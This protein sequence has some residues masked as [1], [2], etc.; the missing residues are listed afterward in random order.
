MVSSK[1]NKFAISLANC[2]SSLCTRR[3][4]AWHD[5]RPRETTPPCDGDSEEFRSLLTK[6]GRGRRA[7]SPAWRGGGA[8]RP[9]PDLAKREPAPAPLAHLPELM[10]AIDDTTINTSLLVGDPPTQRF[11][12]PQLWL[13]FSFLSSPGIR[14]ISCFADVD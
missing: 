2:F 8:I 11:F 1:H 5:T 12:D 4:S 7:A 13:C 6:V 14:D 3:L 10:T 9:K